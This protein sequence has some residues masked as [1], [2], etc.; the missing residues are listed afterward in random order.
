MQNLVDYEV[1]NSENE[2]DVV[3]INSCTVT[4]SADS[5]LRY[6][7]NHLKE[8]RVLV[9]GC[10]AH[11]IGEKLFKERKV[12]GV[13]GHKEKEQINQMLNQKEKFCKIGDLD[14]YK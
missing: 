3:V 12:F 7:I 6:Y 11:S 13:F 5:N 8:K 14:F 2:A 4:N 10:S 1:V 9:T